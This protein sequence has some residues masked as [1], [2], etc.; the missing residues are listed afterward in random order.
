MTEWHRMPD[1]PPPAIHDSETVVWYLVALATQEYDE[2]V[3]RAIPFHKWGFNKYTGD[4]V[5][6]WAELPK[7][8]EFPEDDPNY[9]HPD[10]VY[11]RQWLKNREEM[12]KRKLMEGRR[13]G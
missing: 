2:T 1:D 9:W 13:N 4:T 10:E 3:V 11:A 8:P 7:P 6:A 5:L 12:E